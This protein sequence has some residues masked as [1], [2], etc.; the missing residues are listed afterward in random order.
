MRLFLVCL[1]VGATAVL[2][3]GSDDA[4]TD[5]E[6]D[7]RVAALECITEEKDRKAG[8]EGDDEILVGDEEDGFRIRFYLTADEALGAQ[9]KG[10]GE[11][12]EQIGNALLFVRPEIDAQDE[13]LLAD[14]ESCLAEL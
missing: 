7:K 14:V 10:E 12:A 8:L 3:C 6:A 2:G 1:L 11:G 13:E 9:F 4:G 5:D